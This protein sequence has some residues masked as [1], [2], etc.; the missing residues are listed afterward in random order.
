MVKL[1]LLALG[2]ALNVSTQTQ[3]DFPGHYVIFRS[4]P[5]VRRFFGLSESRR[6]VELDLTILLPRRALEPQHRVDETPVVPR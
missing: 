4:I 3:A 5:K 2:A 6:Q 1:G